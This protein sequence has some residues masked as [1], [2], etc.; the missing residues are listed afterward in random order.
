MIKIVMYVLYGE[1]RIVSQETDPR[2][3][4]ASLDVKSAPT[5][6]SQALPI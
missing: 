1:M 5:G 4:S 6:G 3:S 2:P